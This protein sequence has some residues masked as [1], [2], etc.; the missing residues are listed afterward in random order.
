[1][2]VRVGV[3]GRRGL[4]ERDEVL[5]EEELVDVR[6]AAAGEGLSWGVGW[7]LGARRRGRGWCGQGSGPGRWS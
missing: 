4:D 7:R 3:V 2:L 6:D 1:M 5:V